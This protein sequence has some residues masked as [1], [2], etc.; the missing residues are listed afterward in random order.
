MHDIEP[1]FNWRNLYTAEED[2][3]SPFYGREYSEIYFSNAVYNYLI[4]PQWDEFGSQ[5]LYMKILYCNYEKKFCVLELIGEWNDLLYN[6]IMFLYREV[7]ELLIDE[8]IIHFVLI[9]ENVLTF[10]ADTDDYYQEWFD[11]IDDG[12][13]VCLNFRE[14]VIYDFVKARLDYYL[15]FGGKFDHFNWRSYHPLQ[16]YSTINEM[17]MKRLNP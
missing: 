7:V 16:L 5:T 15:A 8:G 14:H 1:H 17:I 4:H 2:S 11:C 10:H 12:W 6:D 3:R 9:G 13:I